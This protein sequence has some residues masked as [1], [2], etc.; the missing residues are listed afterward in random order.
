MR[1]L[2]ANASTPPQRTVPRSGTPT[3]RVPGYDHA[4]CGAASRLELLLTAGRQLDV[5]HHEQ[6]AGRIART[7]VP[8]TGDQ[9]WALQSGAWARPN[10]T[11]FRGLGGGY[12]LLRVSN[13]AL[14]SVLLFE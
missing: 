13:P 8:G 12:A 7:L 2:C 1:A 9:P 10:P 3:G 5:P 6:H 11:L 4:C 14:P